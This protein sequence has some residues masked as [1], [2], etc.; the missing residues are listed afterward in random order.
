MILLLPTVAHPTADDLTTTNDKVFKLKVTPDNPSF[1][2]KVEVAPNTKVSDAAGN[3]SAALTGSGT[4]TPAGVL[5]VEIDQ[6][7]AASPDGSLRFKFTFGAE[8]AA[9]GTA[10]AFTI[11]DITVSNAETLTNADLQQSAT[12]PMIYWLT[13]T[14]MDPTDSVTVQLN[15]DAVSDDAAGDDKKVAGRESA[16]FTPPIPD[17]E[18]PTVTIGTPALQADGSV[19]FEFMFSEAVTTFDY[20]DLTVTNT[21]ALTAAALVTDDSIDYTLTVM[22]TDAAMPVMVTLMANAVTDDSENAVD[23]A[24][25]TYTPAVDTTP[26][27][28]T[29]TPTF[30]TTTKNV[31]FTITFADDA[32]ISGTLTYGN[33]SVVNGTVIGDPVA[34]ASTAGVYTVTVTP[35]DSDQPVVL[36]V[37]AAAVTDASA[38]ANDSLA[39][40]GTYTP[41][42]PPPPLVTFA[43]T[44]DATVGMAFTVTITPATGQTV[45]LSDITVTQT[46]SDGTQSVLLPTFNAITGEVTFTP[47]AAG[48]VTVAAKGLTSEDPITVGA[49][50]EVVALNATAASATVNGSTDIV[51]TLSATAP[52]DL[53]AADFMVMEDTTV[54]TPAWNATAS[55]LTITPA[56]TGDTTVTVNVSQAGMAKISFAEVVSVSVDRTVPTVMFSAV[57]GAKANVAVMVTITVTGAAP[58]EAVAVGDI[59]VTQ[60]LADNTASVLAHTYNAGVVTFTSTAMSTV[61]VT[62]NAG[63]VMDAVENTNAEASSGGIAVAAADLVDSTAPTAVITGAQGTPRAFDVTITFNEALKAGETL[64][65]DEITVTGGTIVAHATTADTF[66]VTPNH[67]VTAVTVQVKAG[68][69]KDGSDNA[70]AATPATA[71][72]ITVRMTEESFTPTSATDT[73]GTTNTLSGLTIP[74]EG[75]VIVGHG[76][77]TQGLPVGVTATAWADMPDLEGLLFG[78]GSILV[79]VT[80]A[81]IDHDNNPA[82]A[83]RQYAERDVVITEVMAALNNAQVGQADVTAYQ[84]IELYNKLKVPVTVKLTTKPGRPALDAAA[85]EVRLDRLSN[86]VEGGWQFTGLGQ[87]GFVDAEPTTT[88]TPFVSFYRNHRGEPGWQQNRWTTSSDVYL[89]GFYGTP[90]AT[91]RSATGTIVAT[92]FNV[93]NIIF[94]EIANR[95]NANKAYEWIELRNKSGRQNLKNWQISIV[96]DVD[97]DNVFYNFPNANRWI[98]ANSL[99]LLVDKDPRTTPD[100]PLATGW[101]ITK[102]ANDQ[103][104]GVGAHSPRYMVADFAGD[105][106]PDD[107]KFVL[108]LRNHNNKRGKAENLIDIAGFDDNLTVSSNEA[109]YTNLWPLSGGV[110]PA[111]LSNNKLEKDQVHRRQKDNIWGTSSSNYGRDNG[112]H[113][114]DTA[115]RGVVWTSVGYKRNAERNNVHGGTPGYDN[116]SLKDRGADAEAAIVISEI[117]LD[118]SRNLPQWIEI[119]NISNTQGVKLSNASLLIINH[120]LKADGTDYTD[121]KLS[122][123]INID[124]MELPPNQTMLIVSNASRSDTRLPDTRIVNLRRG[125][126]E[127]ILNPNGF[128]ITIRV[129]TNEAAGNHETVDVVGNLGAAPADSRRADDQSFEDTL[130][131]WPAGTDANGN[132]LSVARRTSSKV[133]PDG[134][135]AYTWISSIDDS[136]LSELR[137]LTFYGHSND[138]SSPGQTVGAPLPVSLSS[139]RPT[140]E[141]GEIVIRWT[142]ESELDNAGFN[143]L[144][145]DSRNGEFKQVN[146]KLVQGAGTTGERNTYKWVDET[147]KLGVVYYYQIEDVSFAGERQTLTTTK[148]KGLISAK[149]KRTTLWGGLKEV[150]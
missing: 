104:N 106:L 127:K 102:G 11:S 19:Q 118:T 4:Y 53:T 126:G 26:P 82:T 114:D 60:T 142:T 110:R 58:H 5:G 67:G 83:A 129:R 128:Q 20:T 147:A 149:N 15:E 96:T 36:T 86:V 94:N 3:E 143:I 40:S 24:S 109:G 2:V 46:A 141:N 10:G 125:R 112:N 51:V 62:V 17:N 140:L 39:T 77:G 48:T 75:Y 31:V 132:R 99:L 138:I 56:G 121:N 68:A 130:W 136:R 29:I 30:D 100:H 1:P 145:S 78:G 55:T 117:M 23:T 57:T 33:I 146:S 16:T 63:A 139:F 101:D 21:L 41:D 87:N 122:E 144:R 137:E 28:V 35:T 105:G 123:T 120:S 34:D 93:G 18:A 91:E 66:I 44:G 124:N 119:Q 50:R 49:Q 45:V 97:Q 81:A 32:E 38:E 73:I 98:E 150:Q 113:V 85:T 134:T 76:S 92:S 72:S 43:S 6:P 7:A 71:H 88:N 90:G 89:A 148:L 64:T 9:T 116:G 69:V 25:E 54:L 133:P 95:D 131:D 79:T 103:V 108:F 115:F 80:K 65:A 27:T 8:T 47:T 111:T 52:A 84:W 61:V 70:N 135:I 22:P 37:A 74:A 12:D 107:G 13:V 59:T 14:P 42:T